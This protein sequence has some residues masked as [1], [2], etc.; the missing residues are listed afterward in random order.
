MNLIEPVSV[1]AEDYSVNSFAGMKD[2]R[3]FTAFRS[4]LYLPIKVKQNVKE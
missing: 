2:L 3:G 4:L 1:T